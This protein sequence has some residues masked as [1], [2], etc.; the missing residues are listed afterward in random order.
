MKVEAR[1]LAGCSQLTS[2]DISNNRID[3][4][5]V[6]IKHTDGSLIMSHV[7]HYESLRLQS[8]ADTIRVLVGLSPSSNLPGFYITSNIHNMRDG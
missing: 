5:A 1:D 4:L 6:S 3:N 7:C 2:L 8:H